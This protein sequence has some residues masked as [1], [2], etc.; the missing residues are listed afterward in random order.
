MTRRAPVLLAAIVMV[1]C[2]SALHPAAVGTQRRPAGPAGTS[3]SPSAS[4]AAPSRS[5]P[6][7][8]PAKDFVSPIQPGNKPNAVAGDVN[9]MMPA[10]DLVGVAPNCVADRAAAPSLGLLLATARDEGVVLSMEECYRPLTDQVTVRQNWTAA[11]NSSC[12]APVVTTSTG[13]PKGT[14][15]HG[16]GKAA[17]FGEG[18]G[19]MTF[20]SSGYAFLT[21]QAGRFGWNHP[22][23]AQPG[24]STCPEAWHWEWVGDGGILHDSAV[25]ADVVGLLPSWD[26]AGYCIVTGLGDV[27]A[28]GDATGAGSLGRPLAWLVAGAARTPD[29]GGYW[30]VGIDGSVY[31]FGDALSFGSAVA[32]PGQPIVGMAPSADAHGYW[33]AAADGTVYGFGAAGSYGSPAALGRRLARPIVAIVA[34]PDGRGYWLAG[35]DGSVFAYG[36]AVSFGSAASRALRAPIVAMAA[37][38]DGRG[39]W[40]AG[41]D[42][43][44]FA[45]GDAVSHGGAARLA[46]PEPVVGIAATPD[47]GGYWLI[48]ADGIV[49]TF[50]D[51]GLYGPSPRTTTLARRPW[52][53]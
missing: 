48:A 15:M 32:P 41:A 14:S 30:L 46:L 23:W 44:V 19:S 33:L 8:P 7:L 37:T 39:Y 20:G 31:P 18:A 53:Q 36:D 5:K 10:R 38:S 2:S 28:H 25:H 26:G 16:W 3:P 47:G 29:G 34:T 43:S 4:A 17:D 21:E 52:V 50:G 13:K 6:T 12:A 22:G 27:R 24:G 40:L 49:L 1:G 35:A 45:Y 42:G 11:G 51:A 9:G